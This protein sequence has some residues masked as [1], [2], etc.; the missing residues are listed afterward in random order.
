[1]IPKPD[2]R[3]RLAESV[4]CNRGVRERTWNSRGLHQ[5]FNVRA[6]VSIYANCYQSLFFAVWNVARKAHGRDSS[7]GSSRCSSSM[8][9][10]AR[11]CLTPPM[12]MCGIRIIASGRGSVG[13]LPLRQGF[14]EL[15]F[16]VEC[17]KL[18]EKLNV[19][20]RNVDTLLQLSHF[21]DLTRK[22]HVT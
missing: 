13:P 20:G 5:L 9:R 17:P 12:G 16:D 2:R 14:N 11:I 3:R 1:M 21:H 6:H 4:H 7:E 8:R 10:L 19:N 18:P 15:V 22:I